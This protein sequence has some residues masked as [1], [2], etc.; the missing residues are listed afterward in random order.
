MKRKLYICSVCGNMVDI[1]NSS[2][3]PLTCCNKEMIE[4]IPHMSDD[5]YSEKHLPVC[6][7]KDNHLYVSVGSTPHPS[8][9]K[10][11][12]EWIYVQLSNGGIRKYLKAY[13]RPVACFALCDG[14]KV[15]KI[16]A[17]CNIHGL[18]VNDNPLPDC[19]CT[20]TCN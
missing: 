4:V 10:H 14:D 16:Y 7:L 1:I 5:E 19:N 13:E 15:E 18:W 11:H 17:Y 8:E 2:G 20:N 3:N 6:D 12:I 9:D